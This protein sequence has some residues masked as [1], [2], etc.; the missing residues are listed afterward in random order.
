[1]RSEL[2]ETDLE[3][4]VRACASNRNGQQLRIQAA[5][6][7]CESSIDGTYSLRGRIATGTS[8]VMAG[9]DQQIVSWP[10]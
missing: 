5:S 6:H 4:R 9:P 8:T 1:M 7:V 3:F 10:L 2:A